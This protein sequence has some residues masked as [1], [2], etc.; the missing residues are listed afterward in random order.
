MGESR[1]DPG[2]SGFEN[3]YQVIPL[4]I[5]WGS[6]SIVAF[7]II[8]ILQLSGRMLGLGLFQII[9]ATLGLSVAGFV[10]GLI[11]LKFGRSH[12]AAKVGAFLNG[13][14]LLCIFVILPVVFQILRRLI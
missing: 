2:F 8:L 11:G 9:G 10:L 3:D 4:S 12:G 1:S 14:V 13:V 6:M 5:T 7:V